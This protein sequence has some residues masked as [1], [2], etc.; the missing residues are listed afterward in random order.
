M[1]SPKASVPGRLVTP[2]TDALGVEEWRSV[3]VRVS[4]AAVRPYSE[5]DLHDN[6]PDK[7]ASPEWTEGKGKK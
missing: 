7:M 1:P 4:R 2:P 3:S 5:T 6:E